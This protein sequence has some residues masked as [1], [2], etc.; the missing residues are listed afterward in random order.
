[1]KLCTKNENYVGPIPPTPY[2]TPNSM[3][4]KD[5]E[6]FMARYKSMCDRDYV[7]NIQEEI[8]D[9]CRSDV[10]ILR[11]CCMEFR[12]LFHEITDIDPFT[13]L[14]IP[15]ACHKVYRT[16]YLA[17]DTIAVIPPMG[18]TPKNKHSLLALKWLSYTA[19]KEEIDIQHARNRG[20][21]RVG[22][23]FLDGY[24]EE[25]HT[26]YEVAGC[27]W[28]GCPRCYT[29]DTVNSVNGRTMH[30]LYQRTMK[31][32]EFLK[33]EGYNVVEVWECDIKREMDEDM[34]HYFEHFP[35]VH[36]LEPSDALYGGRTNA[37]KLYHCCEG[38]EQI[39]YVDFTSLYPHVNRTKTVLTGHPEII[40][41]N[42]DEDISNP[43]WFD[44]VH[45][46]SSTRFVS[47][48]V[49]VPYSR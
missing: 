36:P 25:T 6:A 16:N 29:R 32:V 13:I 23:H 21:K 3:S 28:H 8:V 10:D 17:R 14:T 39:K 48:G 33:K 4:P 38:D 9:Y 5:R 49:T 30:E 2:Y 15:A 45:R 20:E 7:F 47:S 42:F 22:D 40:T 44:Q 34:K 11:P 24:H 27:F 43:F 46:T 12:E 1:M 35:I 19:E 41:E 37:S 31:K 18:Y 26:A